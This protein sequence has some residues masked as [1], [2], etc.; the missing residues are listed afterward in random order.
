M[1]ESPDSSSSPDLVRLTLERLGKAGATYS[2]DIFKDVYL[3]M[4]EEFHSL[5]SEG[6]KELLINRSVDVLSTELHTCFADKYS[7]VVPGSYI[8][9]MKG[10]E[11]QPFGY[12]RSVYDMY[13]GIDR[14]RQS[15]KPFC[16]FQYGPSVIVEVMPGEVITVPRL[17]EQDTLV[18]GEFTSCSAVVHRS[19]DGQVSLAH[20]TDVPGTNLERIQAVSSMLASLTGEGEA[21]VVYAYLD[22]EDLDKTRQV[23]AGSHV[24]GYPRDIVDPEFLNHTLNSRAVIVSEKDVSVVSIL[25]THEGVDYQTPSGYKVIKAKRV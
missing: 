4:D 6:Q 18:S 11:A 9:S 8:N 17:E 5:D 13:D 1:K 15:I 14:E 10:G 19:S 7:M 25:A 22:E 16:V 21:T 20:V 12:V 2:P 3:E 23:F 24:I